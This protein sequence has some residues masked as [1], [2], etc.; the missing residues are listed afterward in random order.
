MAGGFFSIAAITVFLAVRMM[1]ERGQ[2]WRRQLAGVAIL[3][4]IAAF[5]VAITPHSAT[6][7]TMVATSFKSFFWALSGILSWPCTP[8]WACVIIQAPFIILALVTLFRPVPFNSGRWFVIIAGASFWMQA[9]ATAGLR[10]EGWDA[11]R[12]YETWSLLLI[13]DCACIYFLGEGLDVRRRYHIYLFAALWI[14]A[15]AYGLLDGAVNL[16]PRALMEK[17]AMVKSLIRGRVCP[18]WSSD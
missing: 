12:Y 6:P 9:F 16:W 5:G 13:V 8:H 11:S 4:A 17:R 10:V 7:G 15:C 2:D 3:A 1:L 18:C 14:L